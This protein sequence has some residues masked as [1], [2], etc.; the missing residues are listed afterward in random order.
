MIHFPARTVFPH[1][2]NVSAKGHLIVGGCDTVELAA[3]YGTPLYLFDEDTLGAL[4]KQFL[5]EFGRVL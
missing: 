4:S 5:Q 3:E 2:T 1:T